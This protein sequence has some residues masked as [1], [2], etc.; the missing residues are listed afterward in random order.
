METI[1]IVRKGSKKDCHD[2]LSQFAKKKK[3]GIKIP[4][5]QK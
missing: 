1:K 4:T 5:I 3:K 2:G